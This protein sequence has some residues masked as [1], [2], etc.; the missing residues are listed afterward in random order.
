MVPCLQGTDAGQKGGYNF[1][2]IQFWRPAVTDPHKFRPCNCRSP[3]HIGIDPEWFLPVSIS[4]LEI[5][6]FDGPTSEQDILTRKVPD[7]NEI[8]PKFDRALWL[9]CAC[10]SL[11]IYSVARY[12]KT[13]QAQEE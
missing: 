6:P 7:F 4:R 3:D 5:W 1:K 2:N 11:H 9:S 12:G 10:P 13:G 8:V